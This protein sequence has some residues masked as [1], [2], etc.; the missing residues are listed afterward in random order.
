MKTGL[1]FR[2]GGLGDLLVSLPSIQL[3]R[4]MFPAHSLS[5]VCRTEYGQLLKRTG[6]V[7]AVLA[8]EDRRWLPLFEDGSLL[9]GPFRHWLAGFDIVFG[10][11]EERSARRIAPKV[12]SLG[13]AGER[14]IVYD[15][16]S[17]ISISR[18][19]FDRTSKTLGGGPQPKVTFEDCGRLPA[20]KSE[21][22]RSGTPGEGEP[23]AG[24]KD[25][26]IVHPGSGSGA[27]CWPLENFLAVI[28]VLHQE[29]I[30]G[31]LVTGEAEKRM[32][33]KILKVDFPPGWSWLRC[34]PLPVLAE[35]FGRASLYLGND[36]GVTH[37][38][39]VCGTRGLA[40][41]RKDL[42]IAWR[43]YGR[44]ETL[45]DSALAHISIASVVE[46]VRR[47]I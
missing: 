29:G 8:V 47:L 25:F 14:L 41:F 21:R 4:R 13:F 6:V 26:V 11:F 28:A 37:L 44:I 24:L 9:P 5:L 33:E 18:Y 39:A 3:L 40:I 1:L 17:R 20:L 35:L 38:A 31:L 12:L 42:E 27:K 22:P 46:A 36:S 30:P 23:P 16:E 2:L 19:F 45:S 32:E 34:P 10:W 43:P 15:P 7:D